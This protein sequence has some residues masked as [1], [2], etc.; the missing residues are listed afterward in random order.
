M[1][2]KAMLYSRHV[3][4]SRSTDVSSSSAMLALKLWNVPMNSGY[5]FMIFN[6]MHSPL[7]HKAADRI[8]A[9]MQLCSILPSL[10]V[11]TGCD[12]VSCFV[13]KGRHWHWQSWR[14]IL[15]LGIF[16]KLG[17]SIALDDNTSADLERFTCLLY[18]RSTPPPQGCLLT[19]YVIYLCSDYSAM[20]FCQIVT[21]MNIWRGPTISPLSGMMK[22]KLILLFLLLMDTAVWNIYRS[23]DKQSL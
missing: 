16:R 18:N 2:R 21:A 8:T 20:E 5:A 22:A 23:F 10:H 7:P 13:R 1:G 12:M 17:A 4:V 3:K 15:S 6:F 19:K 11:F 9:C 14:R